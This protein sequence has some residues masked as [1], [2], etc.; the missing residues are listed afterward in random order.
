MSPESPF[1]CPHCKGE[2]DAR[3]AEPG[4]GPDGS[5][6]A[7]HV[8][9]RCGV[10]YPVVDGVMDFLP[11]GYSERRKIGQKL[12][13]ADWMVRIYESR[14]WRANW[15]FGVAGGIS[16]ADEMS[17]IDRIL[18]LG[19]SEAVLD[20]A[21]GPGLYARRFAQGAST[22]EVF[23][24]DLSW[25]MLRYAVRKA[26]GTG[27][28]NLTFTHGD[29]HHLPFRDD[30]LDAVNC[31][32]ALHLFPD[33]RQAL[34]ELKRVIRPKGRFS[35]GVYLAVGTGPL[36]SF[37]RAVDKRT[38]VHRFQ[39]PELEELL[40]GAGFEPTVYHARRLWMIAGGVRRLH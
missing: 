17:L 10:E 39:Q 22:R 13:E 18:D 27:I 40:D 38:G 20:L 24:L 12:M 36:S 14:L 11:Q 33:V 2:L 23:G 5:G 16:L 25:P 8:C 7:G 6:R 31:C 34:R 30:S 15:L 28:E 26:N 29:A 37:G 19:P 35:T 9:E 32:G 21:C 3:G 1:C 4:S